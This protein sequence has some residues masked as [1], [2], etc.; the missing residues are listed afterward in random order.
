MIVT[1]IEYDLIQ[2]KLIRKYCFVF[3]RLLLSDN[4]GVHINMS[5]VAVFQIFALRMDDITLSY[6]ATT[7]FSL[8]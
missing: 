2:V 1:Y 5:K 7:F 8:L 3:F 6:C 4:F